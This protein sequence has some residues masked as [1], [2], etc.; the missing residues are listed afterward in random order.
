MLLFSTDQI[1]IKSQVK[2][3]K[4]DYQVGTGLNLI[5]GGLRNAGFPQSKK[6]VDKR[7]NTK[8]REKIKLGHI[9]QQINIYAGRRVTTLKTTANNVEL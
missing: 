6:K 5:D 7:R 9:V 8:R 4:P 2:N 1:D 3:V